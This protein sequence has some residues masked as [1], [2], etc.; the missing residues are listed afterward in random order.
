MTRHEKEKINTLTNTPSNIYSEEYACNYIPLFCGIMPPTEKDALNLINH[1][2]SSKLLNCAGIS[3][4]LNDTG[5]QWDYPNAWPPM[6]HMIIDGLLKLANKFPSL[7]NHANELAEDIA[8][9]FLKTIYIAYERYGHMF[10]KYDA[11][12]IGEVGTGGEYLVQRGFGWTNGV[13]LWLLERYGHL[14]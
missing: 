5:E 12:S 14:L 2:K 7:S 9:K 8:L 6:Q 13:A 3:A 1:L 11:S 4:S 10:E